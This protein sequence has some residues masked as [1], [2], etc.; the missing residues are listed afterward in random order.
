VAAALKRRSDEVVESIL[1]HLL[2]TSGHAGILSYVVDKSTESGTNFGNDF[3]YK[4]VDQYEAAIQPDLT[5]LHDSIYGTCHCLATKDHDSEGIAKHLSDLDTL[6][7]KWAQSTS[8]IQLAMQSRGLEDRQTS[9]LGKQIRS[10]AVDIGNKSQRHVEAR[11]ITA[12]LQDACKHTPS[13]ADI[14]SSDIKVLDDLIEKARRENVSRAV[15]D[16]LNLF[17][18]VREECS[19]NVIRKDGHI[20]PNK[21]L[22]ED[23]LKRFRGEIEPAL[24]NLPSDE[25]GIRQAQDAAA[26]F[27]CAIAADFTWADDFVSAEALYSEA[28]RW[29]EAAAQV[30]GEGWT[31]P[32]AANVSATTAAIEEGLKK[33]RGH[34]ILYRHLFLRLAVHSH[35]AHRAVSRCEGWKQLSL[36]GQAATS[37]RA[38]LAPRNCNGLAGRI[39]DPHRRRRYS[40]AEHGEGFAGEFTGTEKP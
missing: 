31:M 4:L 18:T 32:S 27:L 3:V 1:G 13:V 5:S 24:R 17:A 29:A 22:C 21:K 26:R 10:L 25:Q 20:G 11:Q 9:E 39:G 35:T 34:P 19:K 8:G 15:R 23:A 12:M 14:L 36:F 40:N 6:T 33:I 28:L 16:L 37:K 7:K 2:K 38:T 30:A